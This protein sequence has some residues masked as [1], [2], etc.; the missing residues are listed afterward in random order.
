MMRHWR[1]KRKKRGGEMRKNSEECIE[2]SRIG[3]GEG[4][5]RTKRKEG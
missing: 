4:R 2:K 5:R 3:G 1:R